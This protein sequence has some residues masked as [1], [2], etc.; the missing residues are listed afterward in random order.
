MAEPEAWWLRFKGAGGHEAAK[1][2]GAV[3]QVERP[4]ARA[5]PRQHDAEV[6]EHQPRDADR[7]VRRPPPR[8]SNARA[9]LRG[10]EAALGQAGGP[11]GA[12]RRAAW[13]SWFAPCV[14]GRKGGSLGVLSVL[15]RPQMLKC[16]SRYSASVAAQRK[17]RLRRCCP[18]RRSSGVADDTRRKQSHVLFLLA[19]PS[20]CWV[21]MTGASPELLAAVAPPSLPADNVG[22]G[23]KRSRDSGSAHLTERPDFIAGDLSDLPAVT[24]PVVRTSRGSRALSQ[25]W[26]RYK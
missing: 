18:L 11:L 13:L 7:K 20:D 10:P 9:L 8:W 22:D 15:R 17:R 2:V 23:A 6:D 24:D 5:A 3:V 1:R 26:T 4:P 16:H 14:L 25:S 21:M 12:V 19:R